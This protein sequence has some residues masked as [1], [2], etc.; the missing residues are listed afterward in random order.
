MK[1]D[2][3]QNNQE[4]FCVNISKKYGRNPVLKKIDFRIKQGEIVGL[5]GPNGAGK[6]TSFYIILGMIS[7]NRGS[8]FL[9]NQNITYLPIYKRSRLGIGYLSQES[10]IF[11]NLT[12]WNNLE[13]VLQFHHVSKNERKHRIEQ[14][15]H[16][17]AIEKISR[18]KGY[19]LSG[20]ER[21]RTEIAR[22]LI[23]NPNFIL[24][25]EPF[26]GIDPLALEDIYKMIILLKKKQIG[27]LIT[28]HNVR[29]T[30]SIT[31]RSYILFDGN[32]LFEGNPIQI[33]NNPKAREFYLG[34][35]FS[36]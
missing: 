6:T 35:S 14:L 27:I 1:I 24:L 7:P 21:R 11:Q 25:D 23:L 33:I 19:T 13:C 26:A 5:L 9:N 10:S 28:D 34:R 17:F 20:G 30:L 22:S 15:L 18:S 12:V 4:L 8:I 36:L 16:D 2:N 3:N 29:E 31:D 32:I